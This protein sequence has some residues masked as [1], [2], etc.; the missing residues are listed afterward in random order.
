[1][2]EPLIII[3]S[4][5]IREGKFEDLLEA[6]NRLEAFVEANEPRMITYRVYLDPGN[7]TVTVL[8]IHPDTASA[9]NHMQVAATAFSGFG[10]L[11]WMS[12]IDVYGEASPSL[13]ARLRAK[14]SMLGGGSMMVH[15]LHM[16]FHRFR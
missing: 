11:I 5:R 3:D 7:T 8:Q 13:L 2:S 16:G 9:E 6:M 10:D 12:R 1:M 4:S 15:H 14:A